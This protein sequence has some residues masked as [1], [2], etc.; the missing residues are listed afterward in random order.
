VALRV[1]AGFDGQ[2]KAKSAVLLQQSGF[3]R[4]MAFSCT[5]L[6][7]RTFLLSATATATTANL[8]NRMRRSFTGAP[9]S[10]AGALSLVD[11]K[12]VWYIFR[13][14]KKD[15]AVWLAS[16]VGVLTLGMYG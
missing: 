16:F 10:H 9:P 11:F 2:V 14:D 7:Y 12:S 8:A 1:F 3:T 13:V 6:A 4:W 5:I 15:F